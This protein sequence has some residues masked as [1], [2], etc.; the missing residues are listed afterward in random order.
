MCRCDFVSLR[1]T[2]PGGPGLQVSRRR[3]RPRRRVTVF[4]SVSVFPSSFHLPLPFEVMSLPRAKPSKAGPVFR[5]EERSGAWS[6]VHAS[7]RGH[8]LSLSATEADDSPRDAFDVEDAVVSAPDPGKS[9]TTA[10]R[11]VFDVAPR[12]PGAALRLATESK[13]EQESWLQ[14]LAAAAVP[15]AW[16]GGVGVRR[17]PA[18]LL[19]SMWAIQHAGAAAVLGAGAVSSAAATAAGA[20]TAAALSQRVPSPFSRLP[21]L[22]AVPAWQ[23]KGLFLQKLRQCTIVFDGVASN[24]FVADREVKRNTLLEIVDFAESSGRALFSDPR[25]IDD[26]FTAVRLNIF[27]VLP[28]APLPSSDPDECEEAFSDP[29]WP[30]LNIAYEL[31]LRLASS[32]HIDLT[33]KKRVIDP[34]FVR[35]LLQ[36]FDSEDPRERDYLKQITHRIYSKITQRRALIRRVI[37]NVFYDFIY[38]PPASGTHNGIS[39]MLDILASVINGFAVPIK[40]EHRSMLT[41]ALIPLHKSRALAPYHPQLS[42]CMALFAVKDHTL[43][44]DIVPGILRIWPFGSAA[45]QIMLI[46]ELEDIFEYVQVSPQR[47]C[48][49]AYEETAPPRCPLK[50]THSPPPRP[51]QT[52]RRMIWT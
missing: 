1:L 10:R 49:C 13:E 46:N 34:S 25:V 29:L 3:R 31:L 41:R 15:D 32:D 35:S 9:A 26:T 47:S 8:E 45:K 28:V 50:R 48:G 39:E 24:A 38:E 2:S 12:S 40:D 21:A 23:R 36:L 17:R 22:K 51:P 20:A 7:L 52:R 6:P 5:F 33:S 30:H 14:A 37:C 44:R 16:P 42:Y 43:T 18:P 27:R 19:F 11:F 4:P